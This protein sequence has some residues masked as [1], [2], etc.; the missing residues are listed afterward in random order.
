MSDL[1][2]LFAKTGQRL[3]ATAG[4]P[5]PNAH[6]SRF[7]APCGGDIAPPPRER[8]RYGRGHT[9][10]LPLALLRILRERGALD[11]ADAPDAL[12]C[13]RRHADE[14]LASAI[15]AGTVTRRG[16]GIYALTQAGRDALAKGRAA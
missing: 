8:P 3:C 11:R 1:R 13:T 16:R 14:T 15:R 7:C 2:P 5:R 4:C 6:P 12:A 9:R 10:H